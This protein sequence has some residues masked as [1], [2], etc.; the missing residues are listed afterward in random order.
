MDTDGLAGAALFGHDMR[1]AGKDILYVVPHE[2]VPALDA[3]LQARGAAVNDYSIIPFDAAPG[4]AAR[5]FAHDLLGAESPD[6]IVSINVHGRNAEGRYIDQNGVDVTDQTV[7]LDEV[8]VAGWKTDGVVTIG[9]GSRGHEAGMGNTRRTAPRVTLPDGTVV[10]PRSVVPADHLVTASTSN[11]GAHGLAASALKA[12]GRTDLLTTHQQHMDVLQ[13]TVDAG[14]IDGATGRARATV[15]GQDGNA[16]QTVVRMINLAAGQ[17]PEPPA[18]SATGP[19]GPE[20]PQP[21][22]PASNTL[23]ASGK[24]GEPT[25]SAAKPAGAGDDGSGTPP[26]EPDGTAGSDEPKRK[27]WIRWIFAGS[28]T[29]AFSTAATSATLTSA[30]IPSAAFDPCLLYTSDAA[31][32]HRDV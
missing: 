9:V 5:N 14:A 18:A 32:E 21:G 1:A 16:Y 4:E 3:A 22:N 17:K 23:P 26:K 25:T 24:T 20:G 15:G 28:L 6:A 27:P 12:A 13:A 8:A 31:D 7:P 30:H 10:D 29:G 11:W 2:A 19:K